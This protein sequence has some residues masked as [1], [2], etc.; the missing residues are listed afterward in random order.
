VRC[1]EDDDLVVESVEPVAIRKHNVGGNAD[2]LAARGEG[3][4]AD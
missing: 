2:Q 1:S 4:N 3:G